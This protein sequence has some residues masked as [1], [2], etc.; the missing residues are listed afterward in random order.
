MD[1]SNHSDSEQD[2]SESESRSTL[3]N[4][5]A[6]ALLSPPKQKKSEKVMWRS[7]L[8]NKVQHKLEE[9]ISIYYF[10]SRW[11]LQVMPYGKRQ[12]AFQVS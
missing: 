5:G 1:I 9:R 4:K 10:C 2:S 11:S 3:S 6:D 7:Y 12:L 8:Q